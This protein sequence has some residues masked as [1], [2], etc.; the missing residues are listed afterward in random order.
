MTQAVNRLKAT[1]MGPFGMGRRSPGPRRAGGGANRGGFYPD[2]EK[3]EKQFQRDAK[4]ATAQLKAEFKSLL[5]G[6]VDKAVKAGVDK[7]WAKDY[8]QS[9]FDDEVLDDIEMFLERSG[10][11]AIKDVI[12]DL[13]K[14]MKDIDSIVSDYQDD[15]G[16]KNIDSVKKEGE[17][18]ANNP[19]AKI[20][21]LTK[22]GISGA[23][24]HAL[25]LMIKEQIK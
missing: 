22:L 9:Y 3:G 6:S 16:S 19:S 25:C 24:F 15:V 12:A 8:Y 13:K 1:A 20:K 17:K 18:I 11:K 5:Q 2:D 14:T 21:L 7:T 23:E 4:A 10:P